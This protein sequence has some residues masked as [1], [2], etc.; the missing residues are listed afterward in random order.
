MV[1]IQAYNNFSCWID[2]F[3]SFADAG[4]EATTTNWYH[5]IIKV[6]NFLEHFNSNSTLT[7]N[8]V[9]VIVPVVVLIQ[10]LIILLLDFRN[11]SYG[12]GKAPYGTN[13]NIINSRKDNKNIVYPLM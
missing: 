11:D 12:L 5:D 2:L 9:F 8:D 3:N 10:R 1:L 4:N 7:R 13:V 6:R